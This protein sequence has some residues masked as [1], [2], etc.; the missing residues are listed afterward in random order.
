MKEARRRYRKRKRRE[1]EANRSLTLR[2]S[3][4]SLRLVNEQ[5]RTLVADEPL[6]KVSFCMADRTHRRAFCFV[7]REATSNAWLLHAFKTQSSRGAAVVGERVCHA[8][9][10]AFQV[11]SDKQKPESLQQLDVR[12]AAHNADCSAPK[13]SPIAEEDTFIS[14]TR[15]EEHKAVS[16]AESDDAAP[17]ELVDGDCFQNDNSAL[18][19]N[20]RVRATVA[21][22]QPA[23]TPPKRPPPFVSLA[24][25]RRTVHGTPSPKVLSS[26]QSSST[27]KSAA[28]QPPKPAAKSDRVSAFKEQLASRLLNE[29]GAES[30]VWAPNELAVTVSDNQSELPFETRYQHAALSSPQTFQ[31]VT[32]K[33]LTSESQQTDKHTQQQ[34]EPAANDL[35]AKYSGIDSVETE[36]QPG[37]AAGNSE[38]VRRLV[39]KFEHSSLAERTP[40]RP[41][42]DPFANAPLSGALRARHSAR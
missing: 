28:V 20:A 35:D 1:R 38:A 10:F 40:L 24:P 21:L 11:C 29:S 3:G 19:R 8:I 6:E 5:T 17:E 41:N 2:I 18:L 34:S 30:S 31:A 32:Q 7:S 27:V 23:R 13:L 15:S 37:E 26:A 9:G 16:D 25:E 12:L 33:L 42:D 4:E 14:S 36:N 22:S 39:S